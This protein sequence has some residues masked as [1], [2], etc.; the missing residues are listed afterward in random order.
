MSVI[1]G[2][3]NKIQCYVFRINIRNLNF[4]LVNER[5]EMSLDKCIWETVVSGGHS[6]CVELHC[7]LV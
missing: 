7:E 6:S 3:I 1:L 2:R 5:I 4:I